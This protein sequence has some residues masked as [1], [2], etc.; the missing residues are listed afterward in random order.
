LKKNIAKSFGL[1]LLILFFN[2]PASAQPVNEARNVVVIG[3]DGADRSHISEL[4]ER[5]ELPNLAAII[6]EGRL[7]DIDVVT[8]AT[9]TK[10]GWTQL[11]TGYVPEKTGVY[12]NGRYEPIPEGY[13]L[14]ERLEKFF[15]KDNID[16][17][18]VIGKKFN[19]DNDAPYRATFEE[20]TRY[21][22]KKLKDAGKI[23]PK[24]KTDP[25]QAVYKEG[26]RIVER[27]G[28]MT[29]EIPGKPWYRVAKQLDVWINGLGENEKVAE[30]AVSELKKHKDNR[31]F[32][33]V[34]FAQ[35]DHSGHLFGENSREY[36][37]GI[38][39]DDKYS[40]EII[41][42]LKELGLYD[43]TVVYIVADHGFDKGKKAHIYAPFIFAATND[44]A[45]VRGEGTREDLAPTILKKFGIDLSQIEPLLDGYPFDFQAPVRKAPPQMTEEYRHRYNY[46]D[47]RENNA[48]KK[49]RFD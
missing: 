6:R 16:T 36:N 2:L 8:G 34:H 33:F 22:S 43:R 48:K 49:I 46:I 40:G 5:G 29:V 21:F 14:F 9:D 17:I 39:S 38:K 13:T 47:N 45:V 32:L 20:W 1:I 11:L 35:P 42:K 24:T 25:E 12:N 26:G 23:Y 31:F 3:W 44:P 27:D 18:A 41:G 37:D 30:T 10:A 4:L 15:G 7:I 19:V 28:I